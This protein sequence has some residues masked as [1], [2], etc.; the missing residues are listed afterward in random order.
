M[1]EWEET[2]KKS[3]IDT[4]IEK[5]TMVGDA[6]DCAKDI[7]TL[8]IIKKAQETGERQILS[9]FFDETFNVY[10]NIYVMPDGKTIETERQA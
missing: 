9:S 3:G 4:S 6:S 7:E 5:I 2:I 8:A 10:V 1:N